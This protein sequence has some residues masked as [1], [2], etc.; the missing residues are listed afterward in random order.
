M[1]TAISVP[2][3]IFSRAEVFAR[4]RKMTRSS[5]FTVAVDE[6]VQQ[7]RTEDITR[8]LNEIYAKERSSLDPI[9]ERLQA[10]SLPKEEW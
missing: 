7:H 1:K 2:D 8:K 6:Y 4:H 5:L 10:I 3:A 9:L